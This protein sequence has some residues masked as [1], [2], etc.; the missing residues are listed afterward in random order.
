VA[1]QPVAAATLDTSSVTVPMIPQRPETPGLGVFDQVQDTTSPTADVAGVVQILATY[2]NSA[3]PVVVATTNSDAGG[4]YQTDLPTAARAQ[5]VAHF[6]G[7]DTVAASTSSAVTGGVTAQVVATPIKTT[8]KHKHAVLID[9]NLIPAQSGPPVVLQWH[10]HKHWT[11]L[12]TASGGAD[13]H[14]RV[15]PARAGRH[16]CRV[17]WAGDAAAPGNNSGPI[18]ITVT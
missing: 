11:N 3:T 12:A 16:L 15:K 9:V 18:W 8:V 6:L 1:T 10:V 14:F 5:Y 4:N 13:T 7:N 17:V 2:P